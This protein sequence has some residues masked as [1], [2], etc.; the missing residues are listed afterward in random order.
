MRKFLSTVAGLALAT[1]SV[2]ASAVSPATQATAT[3]RIYRPL[4]IS[5][6]RNLDF[7]TLVLAAGTWSGQVISM[8]QT[9]AVTGCGANVTCSGSPVAATYHLVGT[10]NAIVKI[11]SLPFNLT[12]PGT[13]AF[14]PNAPTTV[15][16]G[17]AGSTTGV[18]FSIGGS[19]VLNSTTPDGVY[20]GV[21]A[22]TADYQ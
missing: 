2:P 3:A 8:D 13:I 7:G 15:N 1:T 11:T 6:V 17:A 21:F 12:G 19:I 22:V 5:F 4:Q 10:N 18:D 20:S 9:G 14:A 16:L